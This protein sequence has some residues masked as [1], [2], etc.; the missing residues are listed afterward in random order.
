MDPGKETVMATYMLKLYT[1]TTHDIHVELPH[2]Y[3]IPN[4][5]SKRCGYIRHVDQSISCHVMVKK[6]SDYVQAQTVA[7]RTGLSL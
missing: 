5:S 6:L 4:P 3:F 7:I 2:T 1:S